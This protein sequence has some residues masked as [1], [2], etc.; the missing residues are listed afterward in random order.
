MSGHL[1]IVTKDTAATKH[2]HL[3]LVLSNGY[4][5][6]YND[7][8]RFGL[9]LYSAA[10]PETHRPLSQ[11]GPE[12]FAES[13]QGDY[14]FHRAKNKSQAIKSFIMANEIVVGV[15]NIY[16]TESLFLAGIHPQRPAGSL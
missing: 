12:P 3:D 10:N 11:L 15:G 13:F 1:R 14:L 16:A 6:R 7:P 4:I 5:L 8:R 9:W 2:D